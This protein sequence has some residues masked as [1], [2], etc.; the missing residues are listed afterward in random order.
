VLVEQPGDERII[1]ASLRRYLYERRQELNAELGAEKLA[2]NVVKEAA[3]N[4]AIAENTLFDVELE[5]AI[6]EAAGKGQ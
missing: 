6:R 4:A 3:A 5:Q 2:G 1:A